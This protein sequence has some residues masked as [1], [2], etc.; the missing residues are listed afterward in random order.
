MLTM[1]RLKMPHVSRRFFVLLVAYA[2]VFASFNVIEPGKDGV[3]AQTVVDGN[4]TQNTTWDLA[5]SPYLVESDVAIEANATLTIEAG[6]AV[7]FN[8]RC[9][10]FVY[11]Q[12]VAKGNETAKVVFTSNSTS[13]SRG[14]WDDIEVMGGGRAVMDYV[15]VSYGDW[16]VILGSDGSITN[17]T[18]YE[19]WEAIVLWDSSRPL[20]YNNTIIYNGEGI[21][22]LRVD[23]AT[24]ERNAIVGNLHGIYINLTENSE[25]RSNF[26]S[27]N[28]G[29]GL[30]LTEPSGNLITCNNISWN[31]F[32]EVLLSFYFV[33]AYSTIYH[34]NIF[35]TS[36]HAIDWKGSNNWDN[37]SEG[38]YWSNYTGSDP[39]GDG[40]GNEPFIIDENSQDN[41]PLMNP[42]THCDVPYL[43]LPPTADAKASKTLEDENIF[44]W[45]SGNDSFDRDGTIV[46]YTWDFGDGSAG[47]SMYL[48]HS[49]SH[50]GHYIVILTVRDDYGNTGL[51]VI[52]ITIRDFDNLPP[53]AVAKPDYQQV[54]E[55]TQV[56][57][58]GNL[59]YDDDG[60]VVEYRWYFGDGR[61]GDG[62]Q[63]SHTYWQPG[64]YTISLTVYDDDRDWDVDTC[65]VKV[66]EAPK[67]KLPVA[68]AKPYNQT[69]L[70][71][72][73]VWFYG[74]ESYDPDGTIVN[75]TW[76][77]GL[78]NQSWGW[79]D[80]VSHVYNKSGD[81]MVTLTVRDN[82]GTTDYDFCF[83]K[84]L[85]SHPLLKGAQLSGGSLQ[86]VVITW[87]LSPDDGG[88]SNLVSNY[89]IFWS[90]TYDGDGNNYQFLAEVPAGQNSYVHLNAG[91]GDWSNYFYIVKANDTMGYS[92]WE[93]QAGKFVRYME[94]GMRT[95][96]I[97]LIQSASDVE[98]VI[99]TL[100]G[101]Y[102]YVRRYDSADRTDHWKGHWALKPYHNLLGVDYSM[103]LWVRITSADHLVV[104]GLVP[105]STAIPL[106]QGWNF[107]GFPSLTE[108]EV[109]DA[110]SALAF[111]AV[112]GFSD[113][114]PFYLENM[115]DVSLMRPG[116]GYW[117]WVDSPQTW[118]I[119]NL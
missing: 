61:N 91:D 108:R 112:Q 100:K 104:A 89:A 82:N 14:D 7:K 23:N 65:L 87:D 8:C 27:S 119:G 94:E 30:H 83:V 48:T 33:P 19:N 97:P 53:V 20:I 78:D 55:G 63:V 11:G 5:G 114:P 66:L 26:I 67:N 6:V 10:L 1:N 45:F 16:A 115:S 46:N 4:I 3:V 95:L 38:N 44:I 2:A 62:I 96:S 25:I 90:N 57:F 43:D 47:Y 60:S 69:V 50:S 76:V 70:V 80:I 29:G 64:E 81:Y 28:E 106:N 31:G 12:L 54:Y 103:G 37:G 22:G 85:P 93:G 98:I 86:D 17:S 21:L 13:P 18:F 79:G 56:N 92:S 39:D 99:Q 109:G 71:N 15:E 40:I 34:N 42:V 9:S 105:E 24:I 41:Y 74:N 102:E 49:Y 75:Y 107:V 73:T 32:W 84:V 118:I 51:D 88:G 113:S 68:V 116:E 59:S 58:S 117:I 111:N 35:S 36:T 110:L 101:S 77:F 72:E 52:H